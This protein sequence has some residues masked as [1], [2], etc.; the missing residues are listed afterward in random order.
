MT[1]KEKAKEYKKTL[2]PYVLMS[3]AEA[4][5][6]EKGYLAGLAEG[7]KLGKEEQW[8]ATE[9]AQKKTSARIRELEKENEGLKERNSI[10]ENDLRVARKDR[11]D[12]QL[13]VG[14]D[15]KKFIHDYPYS[16]L[17]YLAN[18]ELTKENAELKN[19]P[20]HRRKA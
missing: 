5:A 16:A 2:Q 9:K 11:E 1:D 8:K 13:A 20:L 10:L 18:S 4:E 7:R 3:G 19:A 14:E 6:G 15:V 17:E 12:L